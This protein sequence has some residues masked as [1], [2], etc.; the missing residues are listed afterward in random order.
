MRLG[1]AGEEAWG[2]AGLLAAVWVIFKGGFSGF[3]GLASAGQPG[4][5]A[6]SRGRIGWA[7]ALATG[8]YA[9]AYPFLAP[10]P[11]AVLALSAFGCLLPYLGVRRNAAVHTA[12]FL[13]L[14]LPIMPSLQFF[15]G[16]PL[17]VLSGEVAARLIN[18]AGYPV[19][20][21]GTLLTWRDHAVFVDAPCSGVKMLWAGMML[22]LA[23]AVL[24]GHGPLRTAAMGVLALA[25]VVAGNIL[26][27][28]ALFF[29]ETGVV[30]GPDWAHSAIGVSVFLAA[31]VMLSSAGRKRIASAPYALNGTKKPMEDAK[32][33]QAEKI[34]QKAIKEG[35]P[36]AA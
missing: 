23:L 10:L 12:G 31:A 30:K 29:L 11:R 13:L 4:G 3:A 15:L 2:L 7:P 5:L 35:V 36:C 14:S 18:L 9:A 34:P 19:V 16:Y 21:D 25:A 17:R 28:S 32:T 26:R 24:R 6:L 1:D 33:K 27:T 22:A 20:R 8:A